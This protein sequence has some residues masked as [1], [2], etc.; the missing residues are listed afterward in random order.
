MRFEAQQSRRIWKH[1]PRIGLRKAF[2]AQQ[3]EEDFRVA[4]PHV[5]VI[6][7]L[8]GLIAEIPPA[9]DDLLGRSPA[10]AE[11]QAPARDEIGGT[12]VFGH[13]E[14]VLVAHVDHRG[15]DLDAAGLRADRCQQRK[16]RCELAGEMVDPE[17]RPVRAQLLGGNGKID[18]LQQ[19]IRG[20][21]GL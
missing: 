20:R 9:L 13:V 19:R 21:A 2:A 15:A 7:A 11:L 3:V 8:G 14:R 16:R 10:D 1:R 17:I 18:G 5:G 4:P 12:G 6:L